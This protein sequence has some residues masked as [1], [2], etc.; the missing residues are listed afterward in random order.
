MKY[1]LILLLGA[2]V[3]GCIALAITG[4]DRYSVMFGPEGISKNNLDK[5]WRIRK[6]S[7][8]GICPMVGATTTTTSTTT[9]TTTTSTTTTTLYGSPSRA[10]L[11]TARGL[12]D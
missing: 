2:I 4:G 12:L 10:F 5:L 3:G 1:I 11:S 9:T 7:S 8:E 6:V